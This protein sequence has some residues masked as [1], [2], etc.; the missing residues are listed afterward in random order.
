MSR[1]QK[2]HSGTVHGQRP[3]KG[4]SVAGAYKAGFIVCDRP[5]R[6][7]IS[8]MSGARI[9]CHRS[10]Q[11]PLLWR[12]PRRPCAPS[13]RLYANM[14]RAGEGGWPAPPDTAYLPRVAG[15][16]LLRE[17][18]TLP[19]LWYVIARYNDKAL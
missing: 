5:V 4:G 7:E 10:G 12:G 8:P 15:K 14:S 17:A 16:N 2:H 3:T 11:A 6:A 19:P 18:L 9:P 13:P 1:S